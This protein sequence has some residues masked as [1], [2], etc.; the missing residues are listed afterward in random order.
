[1]S[2]Q[3]SNSI[4]VNKRQRENPVLRHIRNVRYEFADDVA[5][6]YV[7]GDATCALYLSI[8]YHVLYPMYIIGRIKELNNSY[9]L[10]ILLVLVDIEDNTKQLSDLNKIS[11]SYGLTLVLSWSKE[12]AARYLESFRAFENKS[13]SSIQERTETEFL[14]KL[15][16]VLTN[17]KPVNKTDVIT[18]LDVF[19]NFYGICK[20]SEQQL[21]LCPGLGEKKVKRLYSALHDSFHKGKNKK[22]KITKDS[23]IA[24]QISEAK[25]VDIITEE[26]PN[27]TL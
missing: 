11:F 4:I 7:L 5:P 8:K 2:N 21:L 3:S 27:L 22:S 24:E 17:V 18:L 9:K 15:S 26:T 20:A 10:K 19:N 12:E 25:E 23:I 14:P 6:D 16:T 1:M 13:S